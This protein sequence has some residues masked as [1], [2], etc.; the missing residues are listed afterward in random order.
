MKTIHVVCLALAALTLSSPLLAQTGTSSGKIHFVGKIVEGGCNVVPQAQ[1][2]QVNCYRD[3]KNQLHQITLPA[4]GN[5]PIMQ[6]YGTVSQRT[7]SAHPEL[8]EVTI[9]Y[10]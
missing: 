5:A 10:F 3:G 8:R 1:I 2:M 6:T 4:A 9:S 7:L